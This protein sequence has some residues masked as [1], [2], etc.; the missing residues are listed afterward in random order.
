MT[1]GIGRPEDEISGKALRRIKVARQRHD[2]LAEENL[3]GAGKARLRVAQDKRLFDAI[4]DYRAESME[5]I[6]AAYRMITTGLGWQ[7]FNPFRVPGGGGD[8]EKGAVL[9][10]AYSTWAKDMQNNGQP[11]FFVLDIAVGGLGL[12]AAGRKHRIGDHR[13]LPVFCEALDLF[14][15]H[16]SVEIKKSRRAKP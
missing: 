12:R 8:M 3:R 10:L 1:D 13:A 14:S 16:F 2:K 4:G 5:L 15:V 11:L 7:G 9:V 6:H